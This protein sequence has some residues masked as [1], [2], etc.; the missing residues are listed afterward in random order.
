MKLLGSRPLCLSA[1]MEQERHTTEA[2]LFN[3]VK[4]INE[5]FKKSFVE[6]DEGW[7]SSIAKKRSE[8]YREELSAD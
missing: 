6:M 5:L 4:I 1:D 3:L 7:N 2:K 8:I